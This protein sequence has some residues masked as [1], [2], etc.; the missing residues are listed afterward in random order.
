MSE[1]WHRDEPQS[2]CQGL[3]ILHAEEKIC[4]GCLRT[5]DEIAAWSAMSAVERRALLAELPARKA[6]IKPRRRGGRSRTPQT[7]S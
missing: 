1:V 7:N 6:R 3:C 4:I 2:P 5:G